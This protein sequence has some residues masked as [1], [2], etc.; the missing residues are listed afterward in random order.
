MIDN[1]LG[2][3][4]G[5]PLSVLLGTD[6]QRFKSSTGVHGQFWTEGD[7]LHLLTVMSEMQRRGCF[8]EFIRQCK[9]Y[10]S[11]IC[12]WQVWN[13]DLQAAL[14]RYGFS[15]ATH[16]RYGDTFEGFKWEK[17]S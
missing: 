5:D 7:E 12:V 15:P 3:L 13:K 9:E 17:Q 10:F 16:R 6:I 11:A 1:P 8:R 2:Q 14:L 4:K